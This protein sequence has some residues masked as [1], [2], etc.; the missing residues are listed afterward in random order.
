MFDISVPVSRISCCA[1]DVSL[2]ER[3]FFSSPCPENGP[4]HGEN[5][6]WAHGPAM[7][8][9]ENSSGP[10][11]VSVRTAH[12][13][14]ARV[15]SYRNIRTVRCVVGRDHERNEGRLRKREGTCSWGE[16]KNEPSAHGLLLRKRGERGG[17]LSPS[18]CA[19][20]ISTTKAT[21]VQAPNAKTRR[22][23]FPKV[24]SRGYATVCSFFTSLSASLAGMVQCARQ[25]HDP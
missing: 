21:K 20:N 18:T 23:I 25:S 13:C 9:A 10:S 19:P 12:F 16:W 3:F 14:G 11:T 24:G 2:C 7:R 5:E 6:P 1:R 17:V 8:R 15:R 22:S 4:P